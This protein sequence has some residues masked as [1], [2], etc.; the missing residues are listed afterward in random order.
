MERSGDPRTVGTVIKIHRLEDAFSWT[1]LPPRGGAVGERR[2]GAPSEKLCVRPP[3]SAVTPRARAHTPSGG[4]AIQAVGRNKEESD[5]RARATARRG[6]P[7]Q[8]LGLG[9]DQM[10]P[11]SP[12]CRRHLLFSERSGRLLFRRKRIHHED[13]S[14]TQPPPKAETRYRWWL[15][16]SRERERCLMVPPTARTRVSATRVS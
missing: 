9:H 2:N 15:C 6:K 10:D 3:P 7:L 1:L 5:G 8:P 14:L 16:D 12:T 13:I 11:L 4:T